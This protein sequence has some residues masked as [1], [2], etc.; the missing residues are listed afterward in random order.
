MNRQQ[1]LEEENHELRKQL[2]EVL[3]GKINANSNLFGNIKNGLGELS[4]KIGELNKVKEA[5]T[6]LQTKTVSGNKY[7]LMRNGG[8]VIN[9]SSP[10]EAQDFYDGLGN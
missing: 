5:I 7:N 9:F 1:E 8:I 4:E 10:K 6:P 3:A 2:G